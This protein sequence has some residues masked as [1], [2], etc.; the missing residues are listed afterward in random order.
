MNFDTQRKAA[1]AILSS[2]CRLTRASGSFLGQCAVDPTPLSDKQETW[3]FQLA[4]KAS[5]EVLT[6]A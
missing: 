1:L 6:D 2:D 4:D 5:V 3:F